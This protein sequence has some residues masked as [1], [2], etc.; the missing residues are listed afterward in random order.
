MYG[1]KEGRGPA[2]L[3]ALGS[4]FGVGFAVL[5]VGLCVSFGAPIWFCLFGVLF[6]LFALIS[7]GYQFWA[8]TTKNRPDLYDLTSK[9]EEPDRLNHRFGQKS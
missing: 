3:S 4:L 7:A 2:F 5:W 8:A 9:K 1:L 6:G